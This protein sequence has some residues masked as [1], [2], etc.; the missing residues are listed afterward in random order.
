MNHGFQLFEPSKS[1]SLV[2]REWNHEVHSPAKD[3][4]G[5]VE[6]RAGVLATAGGISSHAALVCRQDGKPC[7]VNFNQ[8]VIAREERRLLIP[9]FA[10]LR[11]GDWLTIDGMTGDVYAGRS[12]IDIKPWKSHPELAQLS[13]IIERAVSS[14]HVPPT[15]AGMVWRIWDF[16]RHGLPLLR[17]ESEACEGESGRLN[18]PRTADQDAI[19][20]RQR[21]V[22][23]DRAARLNYSELL[24]GLMK[25][26]NR[27]LR[28]RS[29]V[30][31]PQPCC[32]VLWDPNRQI[33]LQNSSQLV[34]FE[35]F[36]IN[37]R[38]PHLI[39]ISDICFHLDCAVQSASEAWVV[40]MV[41]GCGSSLVPTARAIK[42]CRIMVNGAELGQEAIP[43]F[44]TWLRRREYFWR[45]FE[46]HQTSHQELAAFLKHFARTGG[47]DPKLSVLCRELGLLKNG[48]LTAA[49][50]SLIDSG[51]RNQR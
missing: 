48:Q 10:P 18:Y 36:G 7:V 11:E 43:E 29:A 2:V 50:L 33:Q 28:L 21:L 17:H 49:G 35:F 9:G 39:E 37:R 16:M 51:R 26:L 23:I 25:T 44:Y 45:W 8:G 19:D 3:V 12:R 32:R 13:L 41:P 20:A 40:K 14:G 38:I 24:L 1:Q 34:G 27:Q 6:T 4:R 22:P 46:E 30:G 47:L 31:K 5:G 42:A 15:C